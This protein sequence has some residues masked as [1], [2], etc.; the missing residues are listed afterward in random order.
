MTAKAVDGSSPVHWAER[1]G[2]A[3]GVTALVAAGVDV[4]GMTDDGKTAL[5]RAG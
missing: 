2:R 5:C 4:H 1:S 3:E